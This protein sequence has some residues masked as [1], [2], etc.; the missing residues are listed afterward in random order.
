MAARILIVDDEKLIRWS[1]RERLLLDGHAPEEADS[2]RAAETLLQRQPF[3]VGLFDIKL[4]D[5]S[6]LDLMRRAAQW[7]PGMLPIVITAHSSVDSAV[8]AMKQGAFDY[9]GKPF[10]MDVISMTVRRAL[11]THGLRQTVGAELDRNKREFGLD[12]LAGS[13]PAWTATR[14]MLRRVA[15]VDS[16]VLLL[17]ETGAGKDVAAR[18]LHCESARAARPFMNITCTAMPESLIESELFGHE[19][20]AFTGAG[21][22]KAGL[23]ELG[24][25]GTIFL[26]EIGDMPLSL[27][28]KLLRVLE[29]RAF[30]RVGGS[31][32]ILVDCR[33][34]AA[35][36]RNLHQL[37]Q[38]RQFREDLYY[39]LCAVPI[40]LPPLRERRED[41]PALARHF[42]EHFNRQMGRGLTGFEPAA[43]HKLE[44]YVWP[45]N[46]RELRNVIERAV[47][48]ATDTLISPDGLWLGPGSESSPAD[49]A[50]PFLLPKGGCNLAEVERMLLEQAI[51]RTRGNHTKAAELLGITRDQVRYKAEKFGL[52]RSPE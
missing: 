19:Q 2:V 7:Q 4:P 5:G 50:H 13:S 16:T 40:V 33:I 28:A 23:F 18:A 30:R 12:S 43:L 49:A 34:I 11:E 37:V 45:G 24:Q 32:D 44:A 15:A 46:V 27:Q 42:L 9:I 47:L 17:G 14:D 1:L 51:E 52:M 29:E 25:N 36:H 21:A 20:G 38:E 41:I 8:E 3:E 31:A 48:L 10:H 35:T 6:G 22:R 39:R 26:D